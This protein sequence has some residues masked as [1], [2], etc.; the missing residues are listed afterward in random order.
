MN[1]EQGCSL[2]QQC[3]PHPCRIK[4]SD[5]R[6]INILSVGTASRQPELLPPFVKVQFLSSH[7]RTLPKWTSLQFLKVFALILEQARQNAKFQPL[8]TPAFANTPLLFQKAIPFFLPVSSTKVRGATAA[9]QFPQV[10]LAPGLVPWASHKEENLAGWLQIQKFPS[11]SVNCTNECELVWCSGG[12]G[13][14]R[15]LHGGSAPQDLLLCWLT[16]KRNTSRLSKLQKL[17]T[18]SGDFI[19]LC[20]FISYCRLT[21]KDWCFWMCISLPSLENLPPQKTNQRGKVKMAK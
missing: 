14:D 8:P 2:D 12:H 18:S 19:K 6:N 16:A 17:V 9:W 11:I 15:V 10:L 20:F 21:H 3:I 13:R 1:S 4:H 7:T 5:S